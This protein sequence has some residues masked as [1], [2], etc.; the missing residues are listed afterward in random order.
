MF[1]GKQEFRFKK[2][3]RLIEFFAGYGSQALALKELGVKFSHWKICEWAIKSIQAYKDNHFKDENFDYSKAYSTEFIYK[4]L[5]EMGISSN[6]NEPLTLEQV[7]RLGETE[8]R[9]I[10]NNIHITGNLVNISRVKGEDLQ[11]YDPEHYDYILTYSFPCFTADSLVLS[12]DGYKRICDIDYGDFV[13][14]HDNKYHK[15]TNVFNNGTHDIYKINAMGVDEIKTTLN[16]KFYVREKF[17]KGHK[18]TRA[19]KDPTWKELKELTNNDYLGVAINQECRAIVSNNLPMQNEH[20]WWIVGR[21]IGDGWIRQQGGI[22]ICCDTN[23]LREIMYHLDLLDWNYNIVKERTV[24]KIHIPKKALSDFLYQF[25]CGAGNKHLTQDILDLPIWYLKPFIQG[26]MSADG[27]FTNGVFKATSISRELIYG[28]AQCVAKVYKTPY[29][30]YKVEPPK[31]KII[32][33][34]LVNQN[35]WYQLVFKTEKK[36]QDK[37]FYEDGYIW[38]PIKS[39]EYIGRENVYDIEVE[40]SHSFTVQ[41]TVVHN[42]QDLSK[43]GKG[44]GMARDSGTRSGLLWEVERILDECAELGALPQI[45]LMEN[46]PDVIG[47][48]NLP[49]FRDWRDKLESMGYKCYWQVLNSK[50]YGIPQNRERCFMISILGDYYFSF[51]KEIQLPHKLIDILETNVD[52]KYYLSQ[53]A[54]RGKL[55]TKFRTTSFEGCLPQDDGCCRTLCARDYKDPKCVVEIGEPIACELRCDEGIR[56]FKDNIM[57]TLRTIEACGDKH[58]IE[59]TLK[60]QLCDRLVESGLLKPG[61]VINH[62]YTNGLNGKNPNSRQTLEDYIESENGICNCLTTRPDVLGIAV[63]DLTTKNKRLA[64]MVDKIDPTKTQAID[65]YNQSVHEE[66]HT[67]KTNVDKANMTAITQNLRIRK[68]TPRECFRLMGV[69]DKDFENIAENQSRASLYHLAGDSIV[70]AVLVAILSH[71]VDGFDFNKYIENFY[72][73]IKIGENKDE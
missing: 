13:L 20:F 4:K 17:H 24:Q 49:H 1:D 51:P 35:F 5:A 55:E 70:V 57:G 31:T 11:I 48:K 40:D 52:E 12:R 66:M 69:R 73:K 42:C 39:I 46:V 43:A 10:F 15:V 62:S 32:E 56:T 68:L 38:Y 23:E 58:I 65:M 26:Y 54:I 36:K 9:K 27:C 33:D 61:T 45:L 41:N 47:T 16:H 8:C 2:P 44:K 64:S 28:I 72:E 29:R 6:Y 71:F 21:Y 37:A 18:W 34:R 30:I 22:V 67:I 59:P 53:K 25:G 7:K 60:E 50:D 3:I 19:F 63:E 14:S